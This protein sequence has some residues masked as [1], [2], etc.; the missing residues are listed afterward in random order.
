[1]LYSDHRCSHFV[2]ESL[3][4]Y[5]LL[6]WFGGEQPAPGDAV[7][8]WVDDFWMSRGRMVERYWDRC[9]WRLR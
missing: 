6:T 7:H 8:V 9:G 1:V 5:S 4:G 3:L 2:V